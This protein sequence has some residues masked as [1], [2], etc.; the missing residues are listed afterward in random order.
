MILPPKKRSEAASIAHKS[1][2]I[3]R[4]FIEKSH[5]K[6]P[7][8]HAAAG[9]AYFRRSIVLFFAKLFRFLYQHLP[10]ISRLQFRKSIYLDIFFMNL[11]SIDQ[12]LVKIAEKRIELSTLNYD[13]ERYDEVEEELHDLEDDFIEEYGDF[14]EDALMDVHDEFCPETEV[15]S[16]IAY[17]AKKYIKKEENGK[18]TYDVDEHQGVWVEVEQF[19]NTEEAH[20]VIIPAPTRIVLVKSNKDKQ[21]VW[22]AS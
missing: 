9:R 6:R 7:E 3:L 10:A 13:D 16:P 4:F 18:I 14:L 20:L 8:Y 1:T 11:K 5:E 17:L 15:L 22:R 21:V 2:M 19:A 12:A